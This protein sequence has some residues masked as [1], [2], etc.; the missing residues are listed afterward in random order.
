MALQK[1]KTLDNG[2]TGDYWRITT[3][4]FDRESL[5]CSC[6]IALYTSQTIANSANKHLNLIKTFNFSVASMDLSGDIRV[7]LYNKVKT[8][9][10][11]V[12]STDLFGNPI[13]PHAFD[14]DLDGATDI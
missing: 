14:P 10:S 8:L 9:A 11:T 6:R 5:T 7:L 13:T 2:A 12:V 4:I 1:S 3:A